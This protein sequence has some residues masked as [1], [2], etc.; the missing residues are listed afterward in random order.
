MA[1]LSLLPL[2]L[3]LPAGRH[4]GSTCARSAFLRD[5]QLACTPGGNIVLHAQIPSAPVCCALC[6]AHPGGKCV[7]WAWSK[8]NGTGSCNLKAGTA[9]KRT[10]QAGTTAG[11]RVPLP[12]PPPYRPPHP[13]PPGAKNVLFLAVDDMRPN[14][15]AYNY[16]LANTPHMD[17]L[18]AT[19]LTFHR[20]YVQYAY[21]SPS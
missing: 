4:G 15:G 17:Q 5:T 7:A 19:G 21:C 18:A 8:R 6:A 20:A 3:V 12:G 16:S 10:K 13:T 2:L 11:L 14:I 1:V 9:C